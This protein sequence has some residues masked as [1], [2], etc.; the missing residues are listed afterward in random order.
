M[1]G[2]DF[3]EKQHNREKIRVGI[4]E[5]KRKGKVVMSV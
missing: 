5:K 3:G 1:R 4:K 2:K